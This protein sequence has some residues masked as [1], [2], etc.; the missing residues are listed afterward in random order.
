M[1]PR[2]ASADRVTHVRTICDVRV[3]HSTVFPE[4]TIVTDRL[5]QTGSR[6]DRVSGRRGSARATI[7]VTRSR[8]RTVAKILIVDDDRESLRLLD[9]GLQRDGFTVSS[10]TDPRL[11]MAELRRFRPDLIILEVVLRGI[12]GLEICRQVRRHREF[13]PIGMIIV[14]GL[15]SET[16]R[17]VGLEV[18]ADD[19]IAKPFSVR[20]VLARSRAVLRRRD[21][22]RNDPPTVEWDQLTVDPHKHMVRSGRRKIE[23]SALEFR[24]L[25]FLASHRSQ[26]FSRDQ[27]LDRVWGTER[28]VTPRNV[29]VCVRRIR[30]KIEPV[31]DNPRY[32]QTIHGVG[33]R[34][35]GATD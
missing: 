11:A 25:Q 6:G 5:W 4:F 23:L 15:T 22:W 2:T 13:D 35:G 31:P 7:P 28:S 16:D 14:S 29:D 10:V 33:Y 27:L 34:F 12:D 18:G 9:D 8:S 1:P 17:V 21:R 26:V 3:T 32:I 24:L 30:E 19:Y 20:E